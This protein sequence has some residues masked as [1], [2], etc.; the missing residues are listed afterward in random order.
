MIIGL[1]KNIRRKNPYLLYILSVIF[2]FWMTAV[3]T[4]DD[5]HNRFVLTVTPFIFLTGMYAFKNN[6]QAIN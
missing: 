1:I 2:L 4:C 5:W 6:R 3:L